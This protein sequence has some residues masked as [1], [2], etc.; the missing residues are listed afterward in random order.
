MGAGVRGVNVVGVRSANPKEANF[1]ALYNEEVN[2]LINQG[3]GY[4]SNYP[5]QGGNQGWARDEGWKDK[6]WRDRN[7]MA[8]LKVAGRNR[9]P[10]HI[11]A[12]NFK[13]D[14]KATNQYKPDNEG[15][16][17]SANRKTNPRD[18]TVPSWRRGFFTAIHSFLAAHDF[19]N[20][21]KSAAA[22]SSE[23]AQGAI[24]KIPEGHSGHVLSPEGKDQAGGKKEKSAHRRE[25]L[26]SS[27]MSPN[28]LENNDADGWCKTAMNYTKGQIP[29][30]IVDSD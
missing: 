27:T 12:I 10:R 11:R 20:L 8:R 7:Q 5:R 17:P 1:E 15:K 19:D 23:E 9:P 28:D 26:R 6:E 24:V 3:G 18:P 29:E 25:V 16:K 14:E 22:E 21:S 4:C 2:F 30:S 13:K